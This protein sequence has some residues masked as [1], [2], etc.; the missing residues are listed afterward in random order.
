MRP[1]CLSATPSNHSPL[2]AHHTHSPLPF[3]A[4]VQLC[5]PFFRMLQRWIFEGELEDPHGE[6]F[7]AENKK[8]PASDLWRVCGEERQRDM[9]ERVRA[10]WPTSR[11]EQNV[12]RRGLFEQGKRVIG[13]VHRG[14][15]RSAHLRSRQRT[16]IAFR[17]S[18]PLRRPSD[19]WMNRRRCRQSGRLW[20][21]NG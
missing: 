13:R 10:D 21:C 6:F 7:V 11:R 20:A 3:L 15:Q 18:C 4:A 16:G 12:P 2:L 1:R 17:V 8:T 5:A 19:C 9:E 14:A